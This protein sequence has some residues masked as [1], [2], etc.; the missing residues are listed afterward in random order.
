MCCWILE[1]VSSAVFAKFGGQL[2]TSEMSSLQKDVARAAAAVRQAKALVVCA[3]AGMGVDS[4]L[5]DFRGP[6]GLWKAYP[7][8]KER[9]LTLPAMSTPHWFETDPAFAWGFFG[10][11]MKLY[12]SVSPHDGFAILKRWGEAMPNGCFVF[13]SNV[14]GHFQRA[15]FSEEQVEECHGS[16]RFMQCCRHSGDTRCP[17]RFEIWPSSGV[18]LEVDEA[19]L[20]AKK[21]LPSCPGCNQM[22]RPNVLMFDD[23]YWVP[24]RTN[25]QSQLFVHFTRKI[26]ESGEPFVVVEIGAGQAVPTVRFTSERLVRKPGGVLIRI[27]PREPEVPNER[28]VSLATGGLNA[29]RAIDELLSLSSS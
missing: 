15:G 7:P 5:P 12:N 24:Y 25:E 10:H 27:N 16:L 18:H 28:H 11:R 26:Y 17:K 20:H 19:T 1:R 23:F 14:D 8:L 9:G 6:E 13:T 22:A 21:P 3:G 4:G 2:L 29:L